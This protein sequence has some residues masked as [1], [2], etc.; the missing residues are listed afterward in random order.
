MFGAIVHER[1]PKADI[2]LK[3]VQSNCKYPRKLI[4]VKIL[5]SAPSVSTPRFG[6][7]TVYLWVKGKTRV[8]VDKS[9]AWITTSSFPTSFMLGTL[10]QAEIFP[11]SSN[12]SAN[13]GKGTTDSAAG[14]EESIVAFEDVLIMNGESTNTI[15]FNQRQSYLNQ[16]VADMKLTSDI[17]RDPGVYCVK[18]WFYT[19]NLIKE[20]K[21]YN[22][23]KQPEWLYILTKDGTTFFTKFYDDIVIKE[24]TTDSKQSAVGTEIVRLVY[25]IIDDEPDQYELRIP[26]KD[27]EDEESRA[28]VRTL[29]T[30]KW[31]AGLKDGTS[32]KCRRIPGFDNLEPYGLASN[33]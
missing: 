18:P 27:G 6:G 3:A 5:Q 23:V 33:L 21:G 25:R 19:R 20:I 26:N 30:S 15:P 29:W 22:W 13:S 7:R 14:L 17:S 11:T 1:H 10:L 2:I 9:T 16:M 31:L 4:N 12:V 32:V 24:E 8:W 28:C